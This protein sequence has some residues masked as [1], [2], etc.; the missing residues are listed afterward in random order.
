M[1]PPLSLDTTVEIVLLIACTGIGIATL[2]DLVRYSVFHDKGVLSWQVLRL[3]NR[4]TMQGSF[5]KIMGL[6]Y[7]ESSFRIAL[8]LRLASAITMVILLLSGVE[9]RSLRFILVLFILL[10][11]LLISMRSLYGL[12]GAHQMN[13]ILFLGLTIYFLT[14]PGSFAQTFC[15]LFIGAQ[16]ITSY[17]VSGVYKWMGKM[18]RNGTALAGIMSARIYGHEWLGSYLR[19]RPHL[20]KWMCRGVIAFETSFIVTTFGPSWLLYMFLVA[21]VVFHILNAIFMGLNG[22]FFSFV[23]SYPAII[24]FNYY[25]RALLFA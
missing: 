14:T 25:I 3:S 18:W 1:N 4:N 2:E 13:L 8:G 9:W 23:A 12:D 6:L 19:T 21:G 7:H 15:I 11:T 16:S 5:G 10:F 22:F 17:V 20:S 24:Y